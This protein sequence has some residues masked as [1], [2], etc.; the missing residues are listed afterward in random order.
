[1]RV[2]SIIHEHEAGPGVFAEAAAARGDE[3]E[4]WVP[5]EAPPPELEGFGAV[6][7]FGGSMHV[8]QEEAN[9]WLPREKEVLRSVLEAGTPVLGVCL[10][11]QLLAEAAGGTARRA[12]RP[13]IG[14]HAVELG[15]PAAGDPLLGPLPERFEGF[16]WHSYEFTL[17]PG[18]KP[19]A[20]SD[21]CLQAYRI[22]GSGDSRAP[23]WGIQFH[24]EVTLEIVNR[25][26]DDYREDGDAVRIGIDPERI[27]TESMGRIEAW[28][29]LGRGICTRFLEQVELLASD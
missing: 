26:L 24:A 6:L 29:A 14:W 13:E 25:W 20:H 15:P 12:S 1:V 11:S 19:L 17:P 18:A 10:G 3:L 2:L 27:R 16:E 7:V 9:P 23:S 4:A 21:L 28:N 5:P 8:D 22:D